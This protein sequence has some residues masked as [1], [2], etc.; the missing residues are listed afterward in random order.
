MGTFW[1]T[2]LGCGAVAALLAAVIWRRARTRPLEERLLLA[3]A[4]AAALAVLVGLGGFVLEVPQHDWSA[5]RLAQSAALLR[6]YDLY[7]PADSGPLLSTLYGPV[8]VLLYLPAAA[9]NDLT[10][11]M[12]AAIG[13]NMLCLLLPLAVFFWRARE[14]ADGG[15]TWAVYAFTVAALLAWGPT[16]QML[17]SIHVDGPSVG[18]GI[19]SCAVLV[20]ARAPGA[21][22]LGAAAVLAVLAAWTKQVAAP[23][24]AGQLAWLA[25][26]HGK[27]TASRYFVSLAIS[28]AVVSAAF[29]LAF[30]VEP[31]LFNMLTIPGSHGFYPFAP[32]LREAARLSAP[33]LVPIGVAAWFLRT[34][35]AP[36]L[37]SDWCLTLLAFLVL[38]PT[39]I[40]AR[41]KQGGFLNSY[42]SQYYLI[43]TAGVVT[44]RLL[45]RRE[46]PALARVLLVGACLYVTALLPLPRAKR[47]YDRVS[48]LLHDNKQRQA[49]DF[50]AAHP[51]EALFP[52]SPLATL[53]ADGALYHF[54]WA[55]YDRNKAGYSP[56]DAHVRAH[57]PE[58]LK[59]VVYPRRIV[60][61]RQPPKMILL[62]RLPEFTEPVDLPEAPDWVAFMREEDAPGR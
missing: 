60:E 31:M 6:G 35:G 29:A 55:V 5:A 40:L 16:Q 52:W 33:F 25:V 50:A 49:Y 32:I 10:G 17:G 19:L 27:S 28:G 58:R 41:A 3:L 12:L 1:S 37:R 8:S 7:S 14:D 9:L 61:V 23:L 38:L 21:R 34:R 24:V 46:V 2:V 36:I 56:S 47:Q 53:F 48:E 26:R 18:L 42:H 15:L 59:Y 39:S 45:A 11:S 57:L 62:K 4:P 44:V 54:E 43:A 30:G 20:G 13:T 22:A 51:G